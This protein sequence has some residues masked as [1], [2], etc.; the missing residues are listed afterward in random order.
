LGPKWLRV[1]MVSRLLWSPLNLMPRRAA[2]TA[3]LITAFVAGCGDEASSDPSGS[4]SLNGEGGPVA[5]GPDGLP[6]GPDGKPL[7]PKLE[8]L[9]ELSSEFDLTT[10]GVFPNGV[11]DT[12]KALSNFREKPSQTLVDLMDVANVPVITTVLGLMPSAIRDYVLGFIDEHVFKALYQAVPLTQTLTSMVDDLASIATKFQV[13]TK[14]DLPPGD[15]IGNAKAKHTI[16][17]LGYLWNGERHVVSAPELVS[18]FTAQTADAN[19]VAL[20]R[21]SPD[22]ETGRLKLGAHTFS[23]PVG[24]FAVH[25]FDE[26]A[27]AKFGAASLRDALGKVVNCDGLASSVATQCIDPWGPGKICVGHE[28]DIKEICTTGLDLLVDAIKGQFARLDLPLVRFKEGLTQMWDAPTPNGPLDA[29]VDRLDHGFWTTSIA[30]GN[31]DRPV[32]ATFTGRRVGESAESDA[33][34]R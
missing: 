19:A 26:L 5:I 23:I 20:E 2:I 21:R 6:V 25:G 31:V 3:L 8:G 32:V 9:Y 14:L 17:G 27:K 15:G 10:A 13:V 12:L 16:S 1:E 4:P 29:I 22:I 11:N 28:A 24:S 18:R 34:P 7:P 30:V 33:K